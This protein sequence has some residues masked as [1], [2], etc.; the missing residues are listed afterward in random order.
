MTVRVLARDQ[1][2]DPGW[3]GRLRACP[4]T[5]GVLEIVGANLVNVC[6]RT[7]SENVYA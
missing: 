1:S 3:K 4:W 5:D 7:G 6:V 2:R